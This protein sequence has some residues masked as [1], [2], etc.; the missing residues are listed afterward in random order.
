MTALVLIMMGSLGYFL[1]ACWES[2]RANGSSV[3]LPL[4]DDGDE[5]QP[6]NAIGLVCV[7]LAGIAFLYAAIRLGVYLITGA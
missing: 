3:V 6:V 4:I 5:D 7:A 1:V 2:Q